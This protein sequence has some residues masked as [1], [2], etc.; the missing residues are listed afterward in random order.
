MRFPIPKVR[1]AEFRGRNRSLHLRVCPI[2][3]LPFFFFFCNMNARTHGKS[4]KR[5]KKKKKRRKKKKEKGK[6]S[7]LVL[8][9]V[10]PPSPIIPGGR[11][12]E[13]RREEIE[14]TTWCSP[15]REGV[16]QGVCTARR[17]EEFA[18]HETAIPVQGG[19]YRLCNSE[20]IADVK[21]SRAH[22]SHTPAPTRR[23]RAYL[24]R[25]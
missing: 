5:M 17:N 22:L 15:T 21:P 6:K 23:V 19:I 14:R 13:R 25:G 2:V 8:L 1:S 3:E 10:R 18:L 11:R 24:H 4:V 16:Y 9:L 20:R 7:R 12:S